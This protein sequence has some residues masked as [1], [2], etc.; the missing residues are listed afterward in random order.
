MTLVGHKFDDCSFSC[1]RDI[2]GVPKIKN[3]SRDPYHA[4]AILTTLSNLQGHSHIACIF[5]V[6]LC[7]CAAVDKIS[8]A[9]ARR[10]VPLRWLSFLFFYGNVIG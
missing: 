6:F 5:N 3:G 1:F 9:I 8:T 7:S 4:P 2:I 10:A